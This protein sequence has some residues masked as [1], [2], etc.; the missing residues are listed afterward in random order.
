M[1]RKRL[2]ISLASA[3]IAPFILFTLP[4]LFTYSKNNASFTFIFETF[5]V[6]VFQ[7]I[8]SMLFVFVTGR[9]CFIARDISRKESLV[10]AQIRFNSNPQ[11]NAPTLRRQGEKKASLKMIVL[12]IFL[13]VLCHVGGNYRCFCFVFK[14][15]VVS[16][17]LNNVIHIIFIM[18]SAANP[19]VYAVLKKD[20]KNELKRL[21]VDR[22]CHC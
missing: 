15:C 22:H 20:M 8:P 1:T 19:L 12:I 6:S 2:V 14:L 18:N 11:Q 17:N 9:L 13:F 16:G 21:A 7:L 5:R 4:S 3:W 10:L